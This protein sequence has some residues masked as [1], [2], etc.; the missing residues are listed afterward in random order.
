MSAESQRERPLSM[1]QRRYF[2]AVIVGL[3]GVTLLALALPRTVAAW[4]GLAAVP[5]ID[6]IKEGRSPSAAERAAAYDGL[7]RAIEWTP[8]GRRFADLGLIELEEA[9]RLPD[10]SAIR[11]TL[12]DRS[13]ARLLAALAA[14]PADG[15]AWTNLAQVR[16]LKGAPPRDVAVAL[17]QSL[18][19]APNARNL[20]LLRSELLLNYWRWL[21]VEELLAV[22]AQLRS[23][24]N[25][26]GSYRR[27]L[28]QAAQRAGRVPMLGWAI[29]TD[30]E[31][32]AQFEQMQRDY[33]AP[34]TRR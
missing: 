14:D 5:A 29:G 11:K 8:S 34:P 2:G 19:V 9:V 26:P 27:L 1:R 15:T 33:S 10:D 3:V 22:R 4:C 25:E 16:H 20:W 21:T 31:G 13:E 23:I 28:F 32:Q 18:D 12:L 30:S 24:W 17:V 7:R 6:A